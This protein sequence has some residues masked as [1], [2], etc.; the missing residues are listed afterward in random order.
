MPYIR[1]NVGSIT[2]PS[3]ELVDDSMTLEQAIKTYN[4]NGTISLNGVSLDRVNK[5]KTLAELNVKEDDYLCGAIKN[6]GAFN[7]N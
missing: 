6:G 2:D 3:K 5:S 4:L 7:S 1:L